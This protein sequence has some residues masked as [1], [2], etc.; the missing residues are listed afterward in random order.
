MTVPGSSIELVGLA[1][2]TLAV[3]IPRRL[4]ESGVSSTSRS[5]DPLSGPDAGAGPGAPDSFKVSTTGAEVFG[6]GRS[7]SIVVRNPS[8][9]KTAATAAHIRIFIRIPSSARPSPDRPLN[10]YRPLVHLLQ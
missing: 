10:L 4:T 5:G 1:V 8:P 9:K 7:T 3:L 2:P 6:A